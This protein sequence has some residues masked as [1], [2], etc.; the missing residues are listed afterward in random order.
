M[1]KSANRPK[2]K[3]LNLDRIVFFSD[4]VVAIAI[5]LLVLDLKLDIAGS[6]TVRWADIG[7]L[8]PQF[9]AFLLS[10]ILVALFWIIH[11]QIFRYIKRVDERLVWI[12]ISWLFFIALLP[13]SASLLSAHFGERV[14]TM[15]YVLNTLGITACQNFIWDYVAVRPDYL[16]GEIPERQVKIYQIYF[17]VGMVN[18]LIAIVFTFFAPTLA[19]F[20]LFTRPMMMAIY[21]RLALPR[22]LKR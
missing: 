22:R 7:K 15:V 10:F 5:T 1:D 11:N 21:R 12:N 4:A 14:A 17:N 13:F 9:A 16:D 3:D 8:L 18:G 19:F 20:I 2:E 6:Q